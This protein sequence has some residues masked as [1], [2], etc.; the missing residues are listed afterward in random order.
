MRWYERWQFANPHFLQPLWPYKTNLRGLTR[1]PPHPSPFWKSGLHGASPCL[2]S[3]YWTAHLSHT[4][5]HPER[6]GWN[7]M[8]W[9]MSW[10]S[11]AQVKIPNQ[12]QITNLKFKL[13]WPWSKW[14]CKCRVDKS[15]LSRLPFSEFS[16][17]Q[18]HRKAPLPASP[19][20][21]A[22]S[23]AQGQLTTAWSPCYQSLV[24]MCVY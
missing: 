21:S 7:E 9:A 10:N 19:V 22:S 24:F 16:R 8:R 1:M 14:K 20:V 3:D 6:R 13:A 2:S 15:R 11:H 4:W 23:L 5:K 18:V 12:P 17:K